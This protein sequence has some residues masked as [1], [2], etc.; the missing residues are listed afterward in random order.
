MSLLRKRQAKKNLSAP[1]RESC[2]TLR[3]CLLTSNNPA[4]KT[5]AP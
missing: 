2:E 1:Q 5:V 3:F 4:L